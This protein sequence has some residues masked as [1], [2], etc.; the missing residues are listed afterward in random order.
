MVFGAYPL[1][2]RA[3][4]AWVTFLAG[5]ALTAALGWEFHREAVEM[6]RQRLVMRVTEIT[7]Q[8]DARLEKSE[9][10]LHQLRDY[11]MLSGEN[12]N[13]VFARWCYDN[14]LTINCPW[15]YGIA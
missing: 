7:A 9:M 10:L 5:L 3:R 6:D 1:F 2:R 11:L 12:R 14:G 8:L 13:Q 15:L 4:A